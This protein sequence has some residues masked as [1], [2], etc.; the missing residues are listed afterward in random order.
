MQMATNVPQMSA[1]RAI[2]GNRR[3]TVRFNISG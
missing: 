1:W 3:R 2:A